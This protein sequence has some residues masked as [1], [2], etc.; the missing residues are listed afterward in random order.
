[1]YCST[2]IYDID[3]SFYI[4][5]RMSAAAYLA[6]YLSRAK[7]VS[8]ALVASILQRFGSIIELIILDLIDV[9]VL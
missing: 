8:A 6:S 1:M 5:C 3:F 2:L 7:F 4:F 9:S